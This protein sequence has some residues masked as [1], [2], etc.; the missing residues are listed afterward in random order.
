[1]AR[2]V[3]Y[4]FFLIPCIMLAIY[5]W[6]LV[7]FVHDKRATGRERALLPR[8]ESENVTRAV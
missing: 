7:K 8:D 6:A 3:S 1:M 5:F 4:S 2:A